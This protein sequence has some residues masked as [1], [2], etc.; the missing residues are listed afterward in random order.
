MGVAAGSVTVGRCTSPLA[1]F[2]LHAPM[3]IRYG[4][5]R[6]ALA[7]PAAR[8]VRWSPAACLLDVLA[9]RFPGPSSRPVAF[10]FVPGRIEVLGR[11]TDYAGGRSLVCAVNRGFLF[12]ASANRVGRVRLFEESRE[13]E[14]VEFPL[15]PSITPEAGRWANYPMT[16]AR[17]LARNFGTRLTGVDIVLQSTLPVGSGMSGSSSLMMATFTAIAAVNRLPESERFRRNLPSP[18]DLA[19]YLAC[20]ENGQGYRGLAGGQGVGTFGGS[21]DHAAILLGKAGALSLF[22]FRPASL[23]A[24]V[25]WPRHWRMVVA[26]SG[27]RAEKT[28]EA[29]EKYNLVSRRASLAVARYNERT[30]RDLS[31]LR[32][33]VEDA[34]AGSD[35]QWLEELDEGAD[36]G[37]CLGD[38]VRQFMLEDERH[39][40]AALRSIAARD[41]RGM[42]AALTR[43]HRASKRH[44]WNIAPEIDWLQRSALRLGAA[45]ASGFGAGFGGS[46]LALEEARGA[47]AMARSWRRD[48][49]KRHPECSRDASFFVA[50]PAPG[51]QLWTPDGPKRLVDLIYDA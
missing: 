36:D 1:G 30:G 8:V 38:R 35:S 14:P 48:Y 16:M 9:G 22:A 18:V 11:H 7:N 6:D 13:F 10:G 44:L 39:L 50:A 31:S 26:F 29:L 49:E 24:E 33:I 42:G 3:L 28:R 21:E 20:A 12:A 40:P 34:R 51:I 37:L 32:E 15:R 41:I 43:A 4:L 46:I 27:V 5:L 17:R 45:G 23:L 25:P 19:V 2:M 47:R